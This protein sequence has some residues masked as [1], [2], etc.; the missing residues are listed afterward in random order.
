[1][2]LEDAEAMARTLMDRHGLRDW[3]LAFDRARTRAGQCRYGP[4]VISLSAPLTEQHA[5]AEVRD[6]VLHEIA[7]ALAGPRAGHGPAWR[8]TALAIGCSATRCLPE[9]APRIE[10]EWR[11]TCPAGHVTTQ[12]RRP[13]RVRSCRRCAPAFD[14]GSIFTW[15]FR[16]QR[17]PM[18]PAYV[19]EL[20]AITRRATAAATL[21]LP[22]LTRP[23]TA[24]TTRPA[25]PTLPPGTRVRLLGTGRWAGVTGTVVKLGRTRYHVRTG[26][27]VVTAPVPLVERLPP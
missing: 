2:R 23:T 3:T 27:H 12:H 8:R 5:E 6:T 7:H 19:E 17:A 14:A 21:P 18:H 4:R 26:D 9:D 24:P 10:G 20:A 16:G 1:M 11:G 13:R 25:A 15:T 22:G